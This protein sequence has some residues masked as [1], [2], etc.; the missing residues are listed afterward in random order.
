MRDSDE[1]DVGLRPRTEPDLKRVAD[2]D[3]DGLH[4]G[5]EMGMEVVFVRSVRWIV[6]EGFLHSG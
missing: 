2:E 5:S 1:D 3:L 6:S 4:I